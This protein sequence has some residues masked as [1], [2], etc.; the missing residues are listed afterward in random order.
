MA[1]G[2]SGQPEHLRDAGKTIQELRD[3]RH[4]QLPRRERIVQAVMARLGRPR[5]LIFVVAFILLWLTLNLILRPF[6][7]AFDT[8]TF[9]LLNL[10]SQIASLVIVLT[11]LSGQTSLRTLEEER[12]RLTLQMSLIIDKKV[13]EAIR[14]LHIAQDKREL[15]EPTDLHQAAEVLRK[16]EKDAGE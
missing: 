16:A 9:A 6:H 3:E 7:K 15:R 10:I 1:Q 4:Q 13:T 11:I 12:D 2:D 14:D 5:A 8:D